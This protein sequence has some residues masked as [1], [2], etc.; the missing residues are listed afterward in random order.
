MKLRTE[1][2]VVCALLAVGLGLH[3]L[4]S[5]TLNSERNARQQD[6]GLNVALPVPVQ[7]LLAGNDRY[8]AANINVFR[9]MMMDNARPD[10][11]TVA[12]QARLQ[13]SAAFF[14]PA[15][16]DNY[17]IAAATLSWQDQVPAAQ[18][19]LK[20]A[21]DAR[22]TDLY[23]LFFYGFNQRWFLQDAAGAALAIEQ[24]ALRAEGNN[25]LSLQ[26][27]AARWYEK[28]DNSREALN[29]VS[30][31]AKQARHPGLKEFLQQRAQRIEGL[32]A[33]KEAVE[34]YRSQ[35]GQAPRE[36]ADL[37]RAGILKKLPEDPTGLGFGLNKDGQPVLLTQQPSTSAKQQ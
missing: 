37:L 25:R 4:G 12:T 23:P 32:I 21:A 13:T 16:E 14:N 20:A 24:A 30:A 3:T 2:G 15:H 31:M 29:I 18:Q 5:R 8:L 11:A 6:N 10:A 7:L 17:Y 27:M 22:P 36:L 34:Q 33:L 9:T 1:I 19:V 35:H 26:A 28:M